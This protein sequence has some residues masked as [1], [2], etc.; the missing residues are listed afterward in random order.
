MV[1]IQTAKPELSSSMPGGRGESGF[2]FPLPSRCRR[3]AIVVESW[4]G[5]AST[6][7][8]P[9]LAWQFMVGLV[10]SCT[11]GCPVGPLMPL[12]QTEKKKR[13]PEF[14][15]SLT[16]VFHRRVSKALHR[17]CERLPCK[18]TT[19]ILKPNVYSTLFK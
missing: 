18:T 11:R 3:I 6:P 19:K 17:F 10:G 5:P 9:F 4:L 2:S 1:R 14:L 8:P 16:C 15:S 7:W 13:V 12:C